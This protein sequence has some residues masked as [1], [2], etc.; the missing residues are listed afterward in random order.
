MNT[1]KALLILIL[2]AI[3]SACAA[4]AKRESMEIPVADQAVYSADRFLSEKVSVGTVSGGKD[5]NPAWTSE[6]SGSDSG[7]A[8]RRSLETAKLST[9]GL[10]A[11]FILDANLIE[12][13]QPM[14]GFTMT[15]HTTV[16]YTLRN[17]ESGSVVLQEVIYADGQASPGDAFAGVKRLRLANER[18]AQENIRRIIDILY[19]YSD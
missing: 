11:S 10:T 18:S 9:T 3:L 16:Q 8:L 19:N 1:L 2:V 6:I 13:D 14:F 7:A 4:P 17:A 12:V 15:V 5:T